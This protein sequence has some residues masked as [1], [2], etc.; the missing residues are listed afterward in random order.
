MYQ[1]EKKKRYIRAK[2]IYGRSGR[3]GR[4]DR[5]RRSLGTDARIRARS[6]NQPSN[7][8]TD[9]SAATVEA[10]YSQQSRTKNRE[11]EKEKEREQEEEMHEGKEGKIREA[12]HERRRRKK[13]RTIA[14]DTHRLLYLRRVTLCLW[15]WIT[16]AINRAEKSATPRATERRARRVIE[17]SSLEALLNA[18][19]YQQ[20]HRGGRFITICNL[21]LGNGHEESATLCSHLFSVQSA[22]ARSIYAWRIIGACNASRKNDRSLR[23]ARAVKSQINLLSFFYFRI[24]E[25]E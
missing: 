21:S 5:K 23:L 12:A 3:R 24:S 20:R 10:P 19:L 9:Q 7:H 4:G 1:K 18:P 11:E 17:L 13:N 6:F 22:C 15:V 14:L 25:R 2:R 8:P 16:E